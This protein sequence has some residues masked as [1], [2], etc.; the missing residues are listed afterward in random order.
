MIPPRRRGSSFVPFVRSFVRERSF[1]KTVAEKR[2][3]LVIVDA[4]NVR[5]AHFVPFY[6]HALS[7]GYAACVRAHRAPFGSR[8]PAWYRL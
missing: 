2:F 8:V 3:A 1:A 6:T 4:I 7:A 5:A